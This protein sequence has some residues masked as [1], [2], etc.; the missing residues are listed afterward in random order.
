MSLEYWHIYVYLLHYLYISV[1]QF[2]AGVMCICALWK[3][4]SKQ[5]R[6]TTILLIFQV[7]SLELVNILGLL[8]AILGLF[9][10]VQPL[11]SLVELHEEVVEHYLELL[12][13]ISFRWK[14]LYYVSTVAFVICGMLTD[15]I[16]VRFQN[17]AV[18]T[19]LKKYYW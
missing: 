13:K 1:I 15:G 19:L 9:L 16:L 4:R 5:K 12:T 17:C 8:T 7:I 2:V 6:P 11:Q 3:S 10:V 14:A 18:Y